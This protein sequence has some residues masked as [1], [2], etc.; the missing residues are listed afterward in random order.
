M[1]KYLLIAALVATPVCHAENKQ[2]KPD[3]P[4]NIV[5]ETFCDYVLIPIVRPIDT[6]I[7]KPCEKYHIPEIVA[8]TCAIAL[9]FIMYYNYF[10]HKAHQYR[11]AELNKITQNQ[12]LEVQ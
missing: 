6:Y 1:F 8:C 4:S 10:L 11:L 12:T 3:R 2:D 7:V 5:W 9:P